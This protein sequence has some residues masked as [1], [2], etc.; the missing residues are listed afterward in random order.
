MLPTDIK[1]LMIENGKVDVNS[2]DF[3]Y[4]RIGSLGLSILEKV[5]RKAHENNLSFIKVRPRNIF[6]ITENI[7]KNYTGKPKADDGVKVYVQKGNWMYI[8]KPIV[9][10]FN[11][12]ENLVNAWKV[13]AAKG[14]SG[15]D[16]FPHAIISQPR[17]VEAGAVCSDT[18]LVIKDFT[19]DD[20]EQ[21]AKAFAGYMKS[22]FFRFMMLLAK[23]D[24]NLTRHC[25]RFV[26]D[27]PCDQYINVYDYF[28]IEPEEQE[29]IS[30]FIKKWESEDTIGVCLNSEEN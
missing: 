26:P 5:L 10:A 24:Q 17:V 21:N 13:V 22:E 12:Q 8:A 30:K 25:Y 20:A 4:V 1:D 2:P 15:E 29:F 14:S 28:G 23:N 18:Y 7:E 6:K 27:I 9:K 19:G 16:V 3:P 11:T